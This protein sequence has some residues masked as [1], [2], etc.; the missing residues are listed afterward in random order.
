MDKVNFKYNYFVS[1]V[2]DDCFGMI[3]IAMTKPIL[4]YNDI[5]A[6]SEIIK[7]RVKSPSIVIILNFILL[8]KND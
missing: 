7:E 4:S 3:D 2:H 5:K 1:F 6:V 8:A